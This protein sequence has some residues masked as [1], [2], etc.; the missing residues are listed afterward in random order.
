MDFR[1]LG[2][3]ATRNWCIEFTKKS[4]I[5]NRINITIAYIYIIIYLRIVDIY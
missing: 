4:G 2:K 3:A 1:N 5:S